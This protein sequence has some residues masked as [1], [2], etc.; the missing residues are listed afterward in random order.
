MRALPI[1]NARPHSVFQAPWDKILQSVDAAAHSHHL[2]STRLEKDV[3][4]P[5]RAFAQR[6]EMQ[7]MH[8]ITANLTA[9]ARDL[10]DAQE[11]SDKL[12]KKGGKAN[13]QKL[14][15]ATS[16]LDS[17]TQQW[18][19]QAPFIYETLQAL[20]EQR[21]NQLRDLLTQYQTHESDRAQ[22]Q[23]LTAEETIAVMLE[24]S[25]TQEIEGFVQKSVAGKPKLEKRVST[26]QSSSLGASTTLAPPSTGTHDDDT[27]DHSGQ[28]DG[29][30]GMSFYRP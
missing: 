26:R 22:G 23:Q 9:M 3:E 19:S 17:A 25:T 27:S 7:N 21:V 29:R 1:A 12:S 20:D 16:R 11:K 5:L 4:L 15:A 28:N 2:F 13:V 24:I 10:E 6:K 18:E 14:D 30:P 8:T